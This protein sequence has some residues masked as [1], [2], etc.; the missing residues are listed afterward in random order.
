MLAVWHK[1]KAFL[2]HRL[3]LEIAIVGSFIAFTINP[4]SLGDI[5]RACGAIFL[6]NVLIG[7]YRIG[8][9]TEGHL[10]VLGIFLIMLLI[11]AFMPAEMIHRR[12]FRYFLALPGM[13]LAIHC[14]SKGINPDSRTL[15]VYSSIAV[16]AVIFQFIT[17]YTV[18]R[19][20]NPGGLESYGVYSNRHHF[21]SVASLILPVIVYFATQNKGWLRILCGAAVIVA[22]FL[23][24]ESS[25]RISWLSFFS[26][27]FI[28]AFVFLRNK[29]VLLALG[30]INSRCFCDRICF[31][32]SR[33]KK[34]HNGY[35]GQLAIGGTHN[36]LDGYPQN[37]Q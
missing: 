34:P 15:L 5:M 7:N 23:L 8:D 29:K 19:V 35:L 32:N 1:F 10:V 17:Y 26:S 36:R 14:L 30:G 20:V 3:I 27:V 12:S 6:F 25:S 37:A 28:A 24:W 33:H 9:V 11:N 22:F 2:G 31:R 13:I 21:G 16:L 18:E 4:G